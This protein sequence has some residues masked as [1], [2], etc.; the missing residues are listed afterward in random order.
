MN[1]LNWLQEQILDF[2]SVIE[3]NL[4]STTYANDRAVYLTDLATAAKWLVRLHKNVPPERV[5][6]EIVS[7][8]TDKYFGDYWRQGK[9]G[10]EE[11]KALKNLQD[12]IRNHSTLQLLVA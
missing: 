12:A 9:W 1:D 11:V 3:Q 8:Q 5:A 4:R 7:A 6:G 2:M 10:D